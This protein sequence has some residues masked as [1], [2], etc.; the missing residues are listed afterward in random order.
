MQERCYYFE[1]INLGF[2]T[3]FPFI[4][5]ATESGSSLQLVLGVFGVVLNLMVTSWLKPYPD[6]KSDMLS[7]LCLICLFAVLFSALLL[8]ADFGPADTSVNETYLGIAVVMVSTAPSAMLVVLLGMAVRTVMVQWQQINTEEADF[9]VPEMADVALADPTR[10][11]ASAHV[12]E[13]VHGKAQPPSSVS[14]KV[15][16]LPQ[17]KENDIPEQKQAPQAMDDK[18]EQKQAR[19]AESDSS[20]IEVEEII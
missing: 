16:P 9:A 2:K 6:W 8:R 15:V 20:D 7:T 1:V 19:G 12:H 17:K 4:M 11:P 3:A 14:S 13:Q 18:Q 10:P 5:F